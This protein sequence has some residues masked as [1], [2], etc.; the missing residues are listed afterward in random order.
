MFWFRWYR[1]KHSAPIRRTMAHSGSGGGGG[2]SGGSD[3]GAGAAV[4]T[5][6][7]QQHATA[8]EEIKSGARLFLVAGFASAFTKTSVAPLDRVRTIA[9]TGVAQSSSGGIVPIFRSV[10]QQDGIRGLWKGNVRSFVCAVAG[11]CCLLSLTAGF[12]CRGSPKHHTYAATSL[13]RNV[14]RTKQHTRATTHL[15][16]PRARLCAPQRRRATFLFFL[17]RAGGELLPRVPLPRHPLC[18]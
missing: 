18:V 6:R 10:V 2:G 17:F 8:R 9:Q 7:V 3:G 13:N 12:G 16:H 14:T 4:P 1:A 5:T 11:R 15:I